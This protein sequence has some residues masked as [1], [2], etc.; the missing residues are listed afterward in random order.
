MKF[1]VRVV[2]SQL[3][4]AERVNFCNR[5]KLTIK[6]E[7]EIL[8]WVGHLLI[9]GEGGKKILIL[10]LF[11]WRNHFRSKIFKESLHDISF[12][13]YCTLYPGSIRVNNAIVTASADAY[14]T[15][16]M[17]FLSPLIEEKT[18]ERT[19]ITFSSMPNIK[20]NSSFCNLGP[21]MSYETFKN[22]MGRA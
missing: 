8:Y 9:H 2:F 1:F 5:I 22:V 11:D 3:F 18:T 20:I 7:L 14:W 6:V 15:W 19:S 4:S 16:I 21:L 10:E 17:F 13:L 12:R